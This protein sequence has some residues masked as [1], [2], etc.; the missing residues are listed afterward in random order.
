M[1]WH[2]ERFNFD[3]SK[4]QFDCISCAK[5]MFFPKSKVGKYKTCS[6]ECREIEKQKR[7]VSRKRNCLGCNKSFV[8]RLTQIQNGIGLYCSHKCS[9]PVRLN[10]SLQP[11]AREKQLKTYTENLLLGKIKHLTGEDHPRWKGGLELSKKRQKESGKLAETIRNYRKNNP[12]KVRE[13]TTRRRGKIV[14]KLPKGT[15][16]SIGELQKWQ[17]VICKI[18]IA[19]K[20]HIDHIYPLAKG[21]QHEPLNL[22]LLCPTC[23]VKKSA[24]DPIT[25]MQELGFLL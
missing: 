20:Y 21:G 9:T 5:P 16:K 11:A 13:F 3:E 10:A 23:N 1:V 12:E 25:Y 8:P 4:I 22:Q 24:K 19:K 7:L 2:K 18:P 17:C 15:I 6:D 14:G